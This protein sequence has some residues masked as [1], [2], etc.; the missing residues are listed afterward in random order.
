MTEAGISKTTRQIA[1]Y[2]APLF[3][4]SRLILDAEFC[5]DGSREVGQQRFVVERE[6]H[7]RGIENG[8]IAASLGNLA[9]SLH[10]LLLHRLEEFVGLVLIVALRNALELHI[11]VLELLQ[12]LLFELLYGLGHGSLI[13]LE[14]GS[15]IVEFDLNLVCISLNSGMT[16]TISCMFIRASFCA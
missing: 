15:L 6:T 14:I 3:R 5:L 1:R 7:C 13:L 11:T 10:S 12:L 8:S 16:E 9:H 4:G 2:H